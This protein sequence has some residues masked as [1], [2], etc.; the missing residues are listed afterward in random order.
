MINEQVGVIRFLR[1][2]GLT[3]QHFYRFALRSTH[4]LVP[5]DHQT[6]P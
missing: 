3:F 1:L 4:P 6:Y 5:V 2:A